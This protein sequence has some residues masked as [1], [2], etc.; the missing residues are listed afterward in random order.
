MKKPIEIL[1]R[2]VLVDNGHLLLVCSRKKTH[3]FLP[4]GHVKRGESAKKALQREFYEEIG[5]HIRINRFLGVVEHSWTSTKHLHS[6]INLVFLVESSNLTMK[7]IPRSR[8]KRIS[9]IWHPLGDLA[10]VNFQPYVARNL[11]SEWLHAD[12]KSGWGSTIE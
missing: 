9:F 3:T 10:A 1:A 4:G 5:H 6:E 2:G 7:K 8:E 11:L 12:V